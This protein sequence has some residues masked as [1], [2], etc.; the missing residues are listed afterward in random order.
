LASNHTRESSTHPKIG[1]V[2]LVA[3]DSSE[4]AN[5]VSKES[6]RLSLEMKAD[7]IILSVVPVPAI[8]AEEGEIDEDYLKEQELEL[9]EL[10]RRLIDTYFTKDSG[11]LV[12]SKILHGDPADKIVKHADEVDADLIVIGTRGRGKFASILLGS[13]SEKVAHHSKRSVLIVKN[14]ERG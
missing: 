2:I 3:V 9:E 5:S 10:H 14:P 4:Y 6:A 8:P 1:K 12:E 13:V 11:L 7:V